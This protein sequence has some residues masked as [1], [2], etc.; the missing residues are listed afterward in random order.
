MHSDSQLCKPSQHSQREVFYNDSAALDPSSIQGVQGTQSEKWEAHF[1]WLAAYR[2]ERGDCSV[3]VL[4]A[5]DPQLGR[6]VGEQR[7]CKRRLDR[8]ECGAGMTVELGIPIRLSLCSTA[9]PLHS[10]FP[11]Q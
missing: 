7:R 9:Q 2:A 5:E 11:I 6:W 3:P 8:G 1:A 4:W 10:R